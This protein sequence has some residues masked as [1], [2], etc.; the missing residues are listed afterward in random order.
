MSDRE[1]LRRDAHA[2]FLPAIDERSL[3]THISEHL[4]SGGTSV[5]L[6]ESREEYVA[7]TM[8]ADRRSVETTEWLSDMTAAIRVSAGGQA[9]I[10]VDQEIGG[11]QR[12]HDLV[13]GLPSATE[14]VAAGSE[15][16]N[17][18]RT[19]SPTSAPRSG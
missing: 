12:L 6:G 3:P 11:I 8:S 7:R 5:L 19:G 4:E 16:S 18:Q 10:G 17:W 13:S 9:L 1:Q 2:V 15:R 14:A